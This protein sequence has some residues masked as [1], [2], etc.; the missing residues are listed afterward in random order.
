MPHDSIGP[1]S[2]R[3]CLYQVIAFLIK[4]IAMFT[5]FQF[6]NAVKLSWAVIAGESEETWALLAVRAITIFTFAACYITFGNPIS[7]VPGLAKDRVLTA[8]EV[9]K[10]FH[11]T[12]VGMSIGVS[13]TPFFHKTFQLICE[14]GGAFEAWLYPPTDAHHA[15]DMAFAQDFEVAAAVAYA[16]LV[17]T[18][19]SLY[20]YHTVVLQ[21]DESKS[22]KQN[23]AA[24]ADDGG[25][26][27]GGDDGG[28]D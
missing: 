18:P 28:A 16:L 11:D 25:G 12:A 5:A 8:E 10:A 23:A 15:A 9:D 3:T 27:D 20:L 26:D 13:F 24:A 17:A 22:E 4:F 21:P 2:L 6:M 7:G 14:G 1:R 19:L